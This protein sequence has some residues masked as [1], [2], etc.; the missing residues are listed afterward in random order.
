MLYIYIYIVVG[1]VGQFSYINI[2][3]YR[4]K[5]SRLPINESIKYFFLINFSY[6]HFQNDKTGEK[7]YSPHKPTVPGMYNVFDW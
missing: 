2:K 5:A 1:I 7:T 6:I 3:S 4:S